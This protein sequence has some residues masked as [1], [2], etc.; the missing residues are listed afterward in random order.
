MGGATL[1][2]RALPPPVSRRAV[3]DR[4]LEQPAS[5]AKASQAPA[6]PASP[7]PWAIAWRRLKRDRAAMIALLVLL[8][9]ALSCLCAPLYASHVSGTN[10]FAT[11]LNGQITLDGKVL[12]VLE[13]STTGLG[14]GVT[15]IGPTGR[16]GPYILGADNQGRDVAARMLY[17]GRNSLLIAGSATILTLTLAVAVGLACGFFGGVVDGVLNRILDVLWAFPIYLLA[18]SLS[19]VLIAQG[20]TIGPIEVRAG[21]LW[22]P[23]A[24]IGIVYVPYVAR[25]IRGQTLSL[26]RS[27]FIAAATALGVP[28]WRVFFKDL[29][30]NVVPRVIVMVPILL[31]LNMITESSLSFLS[32]GVQPP[33]ASW[34]TIIQDGQ[35][36]LYSRPVV[37]LAPGLA[38]ALTVLALNILG[39]G[40][41][42]AFDPRA[43]VRIA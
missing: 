24:I 8:V 21:S 1:S 28:P 43:K 17:G 18:I 10:P 23:I 31:A 25:P 37:A 7:G 19:I 29:L 22:L 12:S 40:V 13:P 6:T 3:T 15:P 4:I 36:L 30:P 34:G 5:V 2:G 14:L 32:I 38:I 33:D 35:G 26:M 16:W 42:D 11:N 20:I 9:V 27:E 39:D 41:R